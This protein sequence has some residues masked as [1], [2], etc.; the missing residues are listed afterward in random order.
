MI[1]SP[2]ITTATRAAARASWLARLSEAL[3]IADKLTVELSRDAEHVAAV[4]ALGERIAL[5]RQEID[6]LRRGRFIPAKEIPP[7]WI[8]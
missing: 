8:V 2:H 3:E 7:E 6:A 4:A 1:M 5:L